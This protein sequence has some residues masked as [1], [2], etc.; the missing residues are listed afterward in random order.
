MVAEL[1]PMLEPLVQQVVALVPRLVALPM[2]A[3]QVQ[4][5]RVLALR[6]LLAVQ[7]VVALVHRSVGL[8]V[9]LL[10][11]RG[12]L[13]A[14][15]EGPL[16]VRPQSL[17]EHRLLVGHRGPRTRRKEHLGVHHSRKLL[18]TLRLHRLAWWCE[19]ASLGSRPSPS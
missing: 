12:Y 5:P 10:L 19:R 16:Q 9:Q 11:V 7:Q 8:R 3:L 15:L 18:P 17:L 4:E 2:L 6:L 13:L 1:V 14:V